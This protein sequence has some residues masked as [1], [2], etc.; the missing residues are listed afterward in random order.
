MES[1][2]NTL[3]RIIREVCNAIIEEY[4]DEVMTAPTDYD[5]DERKAIADHFM[6][7]WHFQQCCWALDGKHIAIKVDLG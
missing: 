4:T 3:S 5:S 2:A 6:N 1:P 7:R